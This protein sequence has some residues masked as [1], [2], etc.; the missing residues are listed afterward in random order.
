MQDPRHYQIAVLSC[1]VLW[2]AL[3]LHLPI[4]G[5]EFG[6]L[7]G[8]AIGV[9][10]LLV[11]VTRY[12]GRGG[13]P[14]SGFDPRS[15]LIS[16]LS[17]TLLARA[18]SPW[19][20][21][22]LATIAISS[23]F[24]IRYRGKH[25]F[26]PTALALAV[27]SM[28]G[29][30]WL[31]PGQWGG[32]AWGALLLAGLGGL[33]AYRA[34]RAD[35]SL[36]FLGAYSL[37]VLAR[38]LWLGD[39][40]TIPL[41]QLGNGALLVFTFFMISDPKTTPDSRSARLVFGALVA[42][43]AF[44]VHFALFR[45]HG[46]LWALVVLAPVVPVLDRL[47]PGPRYRWSNPS[48]TPAHPAGKGIAIMPGAV[49]VRYLVPIVLTVSLLSIFVTAVPAR[50]F[51][52]F[53][54]A[55]ADTRLFN[56]A[57]QVVLVRDG[58][59]AV[60]TLSNDFRGD[61]KEFAVVIP[62]PTS[63]SREQIHVAER[64][65]IDHLDAYTAPRLV[66]YHDGDPCTVY[67]RLEA[68]KSMALGGAPSASSPLQ[69]R[70]LGVTI[71][72]RYT[73]GEY[74]I[75]ILSAEQSHGLET[76]LRRND[77]RIPDGASKVLGSYL[78]QGMRFFV[79]RVNLEEQAKLGYELLRPLQVAYESPKFMLPIR[80]G[81]VNADGRQEL[82]VY[83]LTRKGR[84]ETTNYR[85]VRLP[86]NVEVPEF[87]EQ[88]FGEVYRALFERAVQKE[89][90]RSVILEYAWDMG[91]CDPCAAD[92]LSNQQL[93]ELG[94]FWVD[95]DPSLPVRRRIQ[96]QNVFVT[97][98]HLSYDRESFPEDL[99][100]Q[101]TSDR[102]NFQGRFVIRHPWRG[103]AQCS[104]AEV[105]RRELA[106][107]QDREARALADL[108]GWELSEI[109]TRM[110]LDSREADGP[111]AEGSEPWWKKLWKGR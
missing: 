45:N 89:N 11:L 81:T 70:D 38:A 18:A 107:R 1:L 40:W 48:M 21:A 13:R 6:L 104:A 29:W 65:L 76:W 10:T 59:R 68:R 37:L 69:E 88:D 82:F 90:G 22:A 62:V 92:P 31:S 27:G 96:A 71:E 110:A 36:A 61:P 20:L 16:A 75:L 95:S 46:Y 57:S 49:P 50:A 60:L 80:L 4:G 108:T 24:L 106:G 103:Q 35:V 9:Q 3:R 72:A 12:L 83:A 44:F 101:Q 7:A 105:Y 99:V 33:V 58:D 54:V 100:F 32:V 66:E 23:K 102:T 55:K 17:L 111:P 34:A 51:C 19:S 30:S 25:V 2:G 98:L 63:I 78:R 39:P 28:L 5:L 15:A 42:L 77:Y 43:G 67:D 64:G 85:T 26:N 93:R 41:H 84:V 52:G 109:R 47:L 94:V 73:V 56:K 91:W 53:Y 14:G 79:A 97:R 87:V 86:S 8:T 74:D